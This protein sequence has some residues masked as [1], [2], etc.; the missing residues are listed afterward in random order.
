MMLF[1]M[2]VIL[3]CS[4]IDFMMMSVW[5]VCMV[6]FFLIWILMIVFCIGVGKLIEL[7]GFF[8]LMGL[9]LLF[10]V[11]CCCLMDLLY[12]KRVSGLLVL[13]W[14]LVWLLLLVVVVVGWIVV[15]CLC[16][17]WGVVSCLRCL[18]MKC[19]CSFFD[20]SFGCVRICCRNGKLVVV[21]LIWNLLRVWFVCEIVVCG[22]FD[23]D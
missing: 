5:L 15:W 22:L 11:D 10:M 8:R 16:F 7:L 23:G 9:G 17:L 12:V 21:F 13:I 6:L 20:V 2:V 18:L 3:C 14:V 19:V 1:E 4:F